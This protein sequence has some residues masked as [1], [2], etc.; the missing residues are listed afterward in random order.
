[1]QNQIPTLYL[2]SF[3]SEQYWRE[4]EVSKLPAIADLQADTI[5]SVMD[6]L[7][8]LFCNSSNDILITRLPMDDA[9]KQYLWE[10][11]FLL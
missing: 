2:G 5:V 1:M 8:F 6:E 11:G 4:I 9:H 7:G 3:N 10:L